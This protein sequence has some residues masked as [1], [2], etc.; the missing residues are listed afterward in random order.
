MAR[1]DRARSSIAAPTSIATTSTAWSMRRSPASTR[2]SRC[3]PSPICS[4]I[5]HRPYERIV[6]D[7][8]PTGHT[9]RLLALPET[10]RAL[11]S[12]LDVMQDKHRFMV[13]ALTH[14]YR[15]DRADDFLDEMR[16]RIDT[17]RGRARRRRLR[18]G[19]RR[20][21][22]RAGRRRRDAALPRESPRAARV[23]VAAVI[24]NA[25]LANQQPMPPI[26]RLPSYRLPLAPEPPSASET[27]PPPYG[28]LTAIDDIRGT[29]IDERKPV[30]PA[31]EL[32]DPS[33]ID[34]ADH[35]R[36]RQGRR[37]KEHGGVRARPRRRRRPAMDSRCSSRPIP[38]PRSPTRSAQPN[39]RVGAC[40]HRGTS[41]T[42]R[43]ARRSSDGR[44][45]RVRSFARH[46]SV[47]HRRAVRRARRTRRGRRGGSR[48]RARPPRPRAAGRRRAV[49]TLDTRR[50][51][52]SR[53][54][55]RASSSIPRRPGICSGCSRCRRSRSIGRT[56][57]CV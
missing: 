24:V 10:F 19:R 37:R 44:D 25:P 14:R 46:V 23:R 52:R 26:R 32:V 3:S 55:S 38:R 18:R 42:T 43:R 35:D 28:A 50:R 22:R 41:S 2:S 39:A 17:L 5:P 15:R 57:S 6:V 47:A 53:V 8:A 12:M 54:D 29:S 40:R 16:S 4:P 27:S 11:L 34:P 49:R 9:L 20:D 33:T 51:A 13:R 31:T 7:T 48:H 30:L 56:V 45:R 1:H 36:R 21:A